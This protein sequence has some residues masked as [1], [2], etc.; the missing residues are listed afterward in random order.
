M[1]KSTFDVFELLVVLGSVGVG[2]FSEIIMAH[3]APSLQGSREG[4]SGVKNSKWS[5]VVE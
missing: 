3:F 4:S 1:S 5:N 2:S